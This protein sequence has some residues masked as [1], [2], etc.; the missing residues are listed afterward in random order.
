MREYR[1]SWRD[2][3]IEEGDAALIFLPMSYNLKVSSFLFLSIFWE[4]T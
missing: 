2:N 4:K 1:L 3:D